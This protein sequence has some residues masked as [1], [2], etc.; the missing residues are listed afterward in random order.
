M[1]KDRI[2][3]YTKGTNLKERIDKLRGAYTL[4]L[5]C[6]QVLTKEVERLEKKQSKINKEV[7]E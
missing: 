2:Q 1:A 6:F 7:G 5:W 4:T 3:V